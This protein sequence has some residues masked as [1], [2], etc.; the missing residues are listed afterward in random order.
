MTLEPRMLAVEERL[1]RLASGMPT[2]DVDGGWA[3]LAAQLE[4]PLAQVIPLR[5][6]S[7][8]RPALMGVAAALLV[9]GSAFAAVTHGDRS[10]H[11][12]PVVS[13][14]GVA[15]AG[16]RLHGAFAGPLTTVTGP[17][18]HTHAGGDAGGSSATGTAPSGGS[19]GSDGTG[20]GNDHTKPTDD[21]NDRDQGTGND[22]QHNDHGGGNNGP[23]GSQPRMSNGGDTAGQGNG[24]GH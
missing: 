6:K 8:I 19:T 15:F 7:F 18:K 22:G 21:P 5:R 14:P 20:G 12:A 1:Q 23:E 24:N 10:A 9:A 4:P 2:P 16:P 17:T 13:T 3:A 11:V